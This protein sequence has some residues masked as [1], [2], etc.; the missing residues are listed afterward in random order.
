[1]SKQEKV[2]HLLSHNIVE[3]YPSK[4]FLRKKLESRKKLT[5]YI[6]ADPSAPNIHL[7]HTVVLQKMREFQELGHRVIFLIGDF[8]AEIGDPTGKDRARKQLTRKQIEKNAQTYKEQVS[9]ILKFSGHNPAEIKFNSEWL[10]N[11]TLNK[12]IELAAH[13][14]VQQ[15]MERDMFRRRFENKQPICL[16]EFLYPLMQGYDSVAMDVDVEIGGTDQTFNMLAGREL[17]K[18]YLNKEKIVVTCPLLLGTDREKM[19]K[20]LGNIIGITE[21]ANQIYGKVMS[22]H[23]DLIIHYFKLTTEVS[24][25]Q[26]EEYQKR[27]MKG[28]NPMEIKKIL[29]Y[30]IVKIYHGETPA[31]EAQ[32][33][34]EDV[35]QKE[36]LPTRIPE[37]P[38]ENLPEEIK[39]AHLLYQLNST[40]SISGAKN[41]ISQGA[42]EVNQIQFT[43]PSQVIK[44]KR[45]M[46]IRVGKKRFFRLV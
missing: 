1:M 7:G 10:R 40:A 3:I 30:E 6:G 39:L 22:I 16:H 18:S 44:P 32:K 21:P 14:T 33:E 4:E 46:V 28:I 8:T 5:I 45:G 29:A 43:D 13:F 34:F 37:F 41:L 26:I 38:I 36:K 25:K 12:I 23:D 31:Q 42:V 35:F 20:S 17:V 2:K 19:S 24:D 15:M 27:L 9:N 11:L